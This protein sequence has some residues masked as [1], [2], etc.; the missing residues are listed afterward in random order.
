MYLESWWRTRER[1]KNGSTASLLFTFTITTISLAL[2]LLSLL[3][4]LWF[5]DDYKRFC[6]L[7][8]WF[9]LF[10]MKFSVYFQHSNAFK[11]ECT[12]RTRATVIFCL[13]LLNSNLAEN[14]VTQCNS[15]A[16]TISRSIVYTYLAANFRVSLIHLRL[17]FNSNFDCSL[18]ICDR[19]I[20]IRSRFSGTTV[21]H[22][23]AQWWRCQFVNT[24]LQFGDKRVALRTD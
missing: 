22:Y 17:R 20:W 10:R 21:A 16:V 15:Y 12:W 14:A 11:C 8:F 2:L 24:R 9:L 1:T 13:C 19:F 18:S 6:D 4:L 5:D 3:L 23:S 7:C